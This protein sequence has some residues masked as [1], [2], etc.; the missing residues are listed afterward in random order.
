MSETL[1]CPRTVDDFPRTGIFGDLRTSSTAAAM[2]S[3]EAALELGASNPGDEMDDH[4]TAVVPRCADACVER[5]LPRALC[6]V[7]ARARA[8]DARGFR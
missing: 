5:W 3:L 6:A 2:A 4:I 1:N 7:R 8:R